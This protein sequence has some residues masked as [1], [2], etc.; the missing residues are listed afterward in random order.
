MP[1][2]ITIEN[3]TSNAKLYLSNFSSITAASFSSTV[4]PLQC[5]KTVVFRNQPSQVYFTT[6][7]N[8]YMST[9]K[10]RISVSGG[11]LA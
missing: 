2:N 10:S 11:T 7:T 3:H 5:M 8:S 9:L 6:N 4:N 1:Q